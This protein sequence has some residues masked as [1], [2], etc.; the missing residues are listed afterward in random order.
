[1]RLL[2]FKISFFI[3]FLVITFFPKNI[4]AIKYSSCDINKDDWY[5]IIDFDKDVSVEIFYN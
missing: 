2:A 5:K 4:L 1:M 3:L